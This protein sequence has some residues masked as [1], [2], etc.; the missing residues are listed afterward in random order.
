MLRTHTCGQLRAT[1]VGKE[2]TLCGWVNSYRDHGGTV[3][4]DLRDRYGLIQVVYAP[5][6]GESVM[7]EGGKLRCEDVVQVSGKVAPSVPKRR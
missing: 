7:A 2:V 6:A 3:F 4:I 5:E 1:D